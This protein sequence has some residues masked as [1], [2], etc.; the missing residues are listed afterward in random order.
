MKNLLIT[1]ASKNLGKYL[2]EFF[3][4]KG[5][6]VIG[7]SR[8]NISIN[9]KTNSYLCD[10]SDYNKTLKLFKNLKKKYNKIDYV[11]SC[12]GFSKKTYRKVPQKKYWD[13]SLDNN[14]SLT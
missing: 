10:L 5:Y 3:L 9:N 11:V 6:N 4:N 12:V 1:G 14:F 2:S 8:K 7:L 13:I